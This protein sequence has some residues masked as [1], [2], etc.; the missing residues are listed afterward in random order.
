MRPDAKGLADQEGSADA[1]TLAD[2]KKLIVICYK[3][4]YQY[5]RALLA[6]DGFWKYIFTSQQ[7]DKY[8]VDIVNAAIKTAKPTTDTA[9]KTENPDIGI[10][11]TQIQQTQQKKQGD[12]NGNSFQLFKISQFFINNRSDHF[13][14]LTI[15]KK[16]KFRYKQSRRSKK[17]GQTKTQIQQMQQK[18]R[19][20]QGTVITNKSRYRHS[21]CSRGSKV[22]A[23]KTQFL[24]FLKLSIFCQ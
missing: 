15:V 6:R 10:N 3:Y 2:A 11:Q 1:E 8:E 21:R 24:A 5:K 20:N 12:S 19:T 22:I 14:Q 23:S 4:Q 18:K 16:D 17:C 7:K 9:K 13:Q